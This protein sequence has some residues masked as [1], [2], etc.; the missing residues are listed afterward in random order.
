MKLGDWYGR[1]MNQWSHNDE[2]GYEEEG[3]GKT[4]KK[5]HRSRFVP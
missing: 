2:E 4:H 3:S 1:M 5:S